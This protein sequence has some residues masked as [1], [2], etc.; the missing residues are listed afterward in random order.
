MPWSTIVPEH[1]AY[2]GVSP[3]AEMSTPWSGDQGGG[4]EAA[5]TGSGDTNPPPA[6]GAGAGAGAAAGAG[7]DEPLLEPPPRQR[8]P[9]AG[10]PR[11]PRRPARRP[12]PE[13]PRPAAAAAAGRPH[14]RA[15]WP[16]GWPWPPARGRRPRARGSDWPA[17]R[18]GRCAR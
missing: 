9:D 5:P 3:G 16:V 13:P 8:W 10:R 6:W 11:Q 14:G 7:D 2:S 12:R 18:P 1:T 15:R 4:G 17:Y